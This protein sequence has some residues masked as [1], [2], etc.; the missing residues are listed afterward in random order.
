MKTNFFYYPILLL[1]IS[2]L[3]TQSSF[4]QYY[5][6]SRHCTRGGDTAEIY[7]SCQWYAD[8][9]YITWNGIF[10]SADNGES[11]SVQ[12]KT[13][14]LVESGNIYGDSMS[15][16]L[17]QIPFHS[18]DTFGISFD[19]GM[20]F[21]KRYFN[22]IYDE[23]AGCMA[24]ELY[25]SGWGMYR[26]TDYGNN[27]T[28]LPAGD[29][30]TLQDVGTLP[31][32]V[33][34]FKE[35]NEPRPIKL[36]YSNDFGQSFSV[37]F[38]N[39][40]G[41]PYFDECDLQRGTQPGELYFV[42]WIH[43]DSIALFHSFDYGQTL[44]FQ[45]YMLY[46]TDEVLFTAGRTP[47]T[48]YYVRREICGTPPCLHSCLWIYFSRDYG[49]TFT[50]YYHDLDSTYTGVSPKE[51]VPELKI[52][53]NPA[54][55]RVTF[56]FGGKLPV[57]DSKI[58]IYDLIGRPVAERILPKGQSQVTLDTRNLVAGLYCYRVTNDN[59][60]ISSNAPLGDMQS[61]IYGKILITR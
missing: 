20:T 31:G 59:Y 4:S 38:I 10:H 26:G 48:F 3:L 28:W 15:G 22:D 6:S 17:F 52:Y 53:P 7:I 35:V 5:Y 39:I 29:S 23:A 2:I 16:A 45:S 14:F 44:T 54:T 33:Y 1:L 34:C 8:A 32:E 30:L 13:N 18:Q 40:P 50:T 25:I 47:G 55:D 46:T 37:S 51:I 49:V 24:G 60:A 12:R 42:I 36:A 56:R 9:N 11:L 61:S 58:T 57:G 27:F 43:Y 41:I 21:E 19:Y